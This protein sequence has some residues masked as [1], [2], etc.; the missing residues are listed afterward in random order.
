MLF[1]LTHFVDPQRLRN[2]VQ[3]TTGFFIFSDKY[4]Y[5]KQE[6]THRVR[7]H[8]ILLLSV[9]P[10]S[11]LRVTT[12]HGCNVI[13]LIAPPSECEWMKR[14]CSSKWSVIVECC[15]PCDLD[16]WPPKQYHFQ[17]TW[18][19]FSTQSL[20]ILGSFISE[21]YHRQTNKRTYENPTHA[22]Q[23]NRRG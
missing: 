2:C 5:R 8:T 10:P 3:Q 6:C 21:L 13:L 1:T 12:K 20:N 18:R 17:G 7:I 11:E 19:S 4:K 23:H 16:L 14:D 9:S 22:D 15:W